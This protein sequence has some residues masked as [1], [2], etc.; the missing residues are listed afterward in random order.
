MG[1]VAEIRDGNGDLAHCVMV[2][3]HHADESKYV[4]EDKFRRY[5]RRRAE[6]VAHGI[7]LIMQQVKKISAAAEKNDLAGVKT[8]LAEQLN[9]GWIKGSDSCWPEDER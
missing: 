5:N 6:A 2:T 9:F 8:A 4:L 1:T 7:K 3:D